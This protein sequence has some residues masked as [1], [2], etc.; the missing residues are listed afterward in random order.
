MSECVLYYVEAR[1][2]EFDAHV[3]KD[4]NIVLDSFPEMESLE[5]SIWCSSCGLVGSDKYEA[6]GISEDWEVM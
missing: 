3:D 4:G 5:F 6:H 1:A 2:A